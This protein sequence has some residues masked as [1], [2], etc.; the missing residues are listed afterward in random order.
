MKQI[1]IINKEIIK[2]ILNT[3]CCN[4]SIS[5]I[6]NIIHKNVKCVITPEKDCFDLTFCEDDNSNI[7]YHQSKC[8]YNIFIS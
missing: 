5:D 6:N 2:Y 8:Q 7:V 4:L 3:Y 1:I